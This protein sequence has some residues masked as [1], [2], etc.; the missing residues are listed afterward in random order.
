MQKW[1]EIKQLFEFWIRSLDA[2][3]RPNRP[4]VN[5]YNHYLRANLMTGATAAEL[6]DLVAQMDDYETSANSASYNLVLKAMCQAKESDAA[7]KLMERMLQPGTTYPP[8]N[9]SYSLIIRLLFSQNEI[10]SAL[11]YLDLM[12]RSGYMVSMDVFMDCARKC[13]DAGRLDT[14]TT[15]IEKCKKMDQ[16]K[17]LCPSWNL[18]YNIVGSALQADHSKLAYLGLQFLARW[19]ARGEVMNPPVYLSVDE[20]L[21]VATCA[22]ASRTSN[23]TLLEGSWSI[24]QRS[25]RKKKLPNAESYLAKLHAYAS[26]GNFLRAFGTLKEFES[27]Y[28]DSPEAEELF[29]PFTSLHP[30]V[31][32]CCKDGFSTLDSVYFQL[33]NWTSANPPYKSV[34]ALNCVILGSA[35][36]WD[37]ERA[38]E[39]FDSI[40]KTFGLTPNIHSYNALISAF[41]KRRKTDEALKV[42]EHMT[43]LGVN[44]N[45]LTYSLLIDAHLINRDQINALKLIDG[46]VDAGFVPAK[47]TLKKVRRRCIRE[48][49]FDSNDKVQTLLRNYNYRIGGEARKEQLFN[50]QYSAEYT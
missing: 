42:F 25:L 47:E 15:I 43:S 32:A 45:A 6:L 3:G 16:N 38:Y 28:G 49:D 11:K 26:F 18:S 29:S 20:G 9:E 1:S 39:T 5:L 2:T 30:L 36:I 41:G 17:A 37:L 50:L 27:A 44:P 35:N 40:G 19:M 24:L 22:T 14:L 33:E 13:V 4:D 10:D 12:L 8:D 21:L 31:V 7:E 34:A 46:M 48:S 23:T